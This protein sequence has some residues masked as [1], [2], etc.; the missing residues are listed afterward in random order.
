[1]GAILHPEVRQ[2]KGIIAISSKN[3]KRKVLTS[4]TGKFIPEVVWSKISGPLGNQVAQ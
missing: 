2:G 3:M 1:V 4:T